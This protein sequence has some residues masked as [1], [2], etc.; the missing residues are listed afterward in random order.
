MKSCR[1]YRYHAVQRSATCMLCCT[2]SRCAVL[3]YVMLC[4]T[5]QEVDL[6]LLQ[7]NVAYMQLER[8]ETTYEAAGL[9]KRPEHNLRCCG[10]TGLHLNSHSFPSILGRPCQHQGLSFRKG[11]LALLCVTAIKNTS[12]VWQAY[13]TSGAQQSPTRCC[14]W[15][16]VVPWLL[17]KLQQEQACYCRLSKGS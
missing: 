9:L 2:M 15:C 8:A 13:L 11:P 7:W 17:T 10:C 12:M 14:C 5:V 16:C 4:C 3:C 1:W 6:L